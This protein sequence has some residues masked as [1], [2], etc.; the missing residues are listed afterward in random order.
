MYIS[1]SRFF[2]WTR[3]PMYFAMK[4]KHNLSGMPDID[5]ERERWEEMMAEL[6]EGAKSSEESSED[7]EAFDAKPGP[8]L[9]AQ[10]PYYNQVEDEALMVSRKYFKGAFIADSKDVH[11]QKLF[12]YLEILRAV[13]AKI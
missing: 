6:K 11:N 4:L 2:N 8:E 5:D 10:L 1:K 7:K 9:E 3:C 13:R 12:K